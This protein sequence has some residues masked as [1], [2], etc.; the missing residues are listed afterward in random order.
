MS[1]AY[2]RPET[3]MFPAAHSVIG[4]TFGA[5]TTVNFNSVDFNGSVAEITSMITL[6]T[7]AGNR[8]GS[9]IYLRKV[10][11]SMVVGPG[12]NSNILRILM[13]KPVTGWT[14][15]GAAM[16]NTFFWNG[17]LNGGSVINAMSP[18]INQ[19]Y[20]VLYDKIICFRF[21]AVDGNSSASA[22]I[23]KV[24]R[25]SVPIYLPIRYDQIGGVTTTPIFFAMISDSAA[26]PN[27]GVISGGIT[28]E[29]TD[30]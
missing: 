23:Q 14:S 10:N 12:D 13:V 20:Q 26:V 2:A 30:L 25:R 17:V 9:N 28:L 7:A 24:V 5:L 18:V 3:K 11:I 27:A 22:A 8:I 21:A 4:G 1:A 19:Q 6:G 15:G 16:N 29:F